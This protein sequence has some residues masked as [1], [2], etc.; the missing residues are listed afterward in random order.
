M[1]GMPLALELAAAWASTLSCEEI[2]AD[3]ALG[4]E[5][6]ATSLRDVPERHRSMQAVFDQSWAR[7]DDRQRTLLSQLSVFRGGFRREAA[8]G[9]AGAAPR[10]LAVLV[11]RSLLRPE[12][13]GR[14]QV[15]ELLRQYAEERLWERPEAAARA[16]AAHGAYYA[17]FLETRLARLLGP[18]QRAAR[19]EIRAEL[20]NVR[21]AWRWAVARADAGALRRAAP[22]LATLHHRS[23]SYRE[24]AAAFEAAAWCLAAPSGTDPARPARPGRRPGGRGRAGAGDGAD[25]ARPALRAPGAR[26]RGRRRRWR[27]RT[28]CTRAWAGRRCPAC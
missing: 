5:V 13:G 24:G 28:R 2:A 23:G 22:A 9:V 1:E 25:P 8:E 19:E 14:Y 18:D 27:G 20:D 21:A 16:E 3:L 6:L 15:H 12:P 7:L 10:T 11:D 26:R 4:L 17:E